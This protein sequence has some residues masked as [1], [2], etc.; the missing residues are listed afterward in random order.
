L[1]AAAGRDFFLNWFISAYPEGSYF[2]PLREQLFFELY[3]GAFIAAVLFGAFAVLTWCAIGFKNHAGLISLC[4]IGAVGADLLF[5]GAPDDPWL[6]RSDIRRPGTIAAALQQ[7]DSRYRIYSLAR[8]AG[9]N[10]Y[11]HTPHLSFDRVYRVLS[12]S[13]PP[14]MHLYHGLASVDEYSELLNVR[15]YEVFGPVLLHLAGGGKDPDEDR[16]CRMI[17]SMLNVKYIISPRTLPELQFESVRS[18]PVKL[19]RNP[20]VWPRAFL[21]AS[22]TVCPDDEAVLNRIHAADFERLSAFLPQAEVERLPARLQAALVSYDPGSSAGTATIAGCGANRVDVRVETD[23]PALL[24]LSD[25]WFPGWR[26]LVNGRERALLRV[27]HTLRG[28]ALEPGES[29]VEFVYRPRS[30]IAGMAVSAATALGLIALYCAGC[31]LRRR[32]KPSARG[33]TV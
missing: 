16:Y 7:D 20:E 13:L 21:A 29:R 17:F 2:E 3:R 4:I 10:S 30:F 22:V 32:R 11:A 9:S 19:Y 26:A 31:L 1:A 5:I 18:G 14:N 12:Q 8:I 6:E 27:N 24:V 25:T 15:Y 33:G 23:K 28:V